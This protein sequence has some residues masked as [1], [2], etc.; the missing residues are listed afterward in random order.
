[1]KTI[2]FFVGNTGVEEVKVD[3]NT[4]LHCTCEGFLSRKRCKHVAWCE[5]QFG[6]DVFPINID[7]GTPT[8]AIKKAKESDEAFREFLIRY[9]KI[10]VV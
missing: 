5:E 6:K 1:M 7:K 4:K 8:Q 3:K 10:E 2:Q 9:G